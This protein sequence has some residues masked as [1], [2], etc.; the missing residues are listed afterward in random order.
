MKII[1]FAFSLLALVVSFKSCEISSKA[2]KENKAA[3]KI[4]V[5]ALEFGKTTSETEN[6]PYLNIHIEKWDG[7]KSF[8]KISRTDLEVHISIRL[9]VKN[10]GKTPAIEIK[11]PCNQ[12]LEGENMTIHP[13]ASIVFPPHFSLASGEDKELAFDFIVG[14]KTDNLDTLNK[15]IEEVQNDIYSTEV[16]FPLSYQGFV[17]PNKIYKTDI[18][19]K[20]YNSKK[21]AITPNEMK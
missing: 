5:E 6:R 11:F 15:I 3:N 21:F 18:G 1:T 17:S 4:S 7:T 13:L 10:Y 16:I 9:R 14:S 8:F 20:I 19:Y 12:K 2:L